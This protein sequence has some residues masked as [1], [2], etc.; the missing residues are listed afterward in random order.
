MVGLVALVLYAIFEI[1]LQEV[2]QIWF[3]IRREI[4]FRMKLIRFNRE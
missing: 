3:V 4:I 2:F 1:L